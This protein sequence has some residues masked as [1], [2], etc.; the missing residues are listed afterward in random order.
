MWLQKE[1]VMCVKTAN[2]I[3]S[4][5]SIVEEEYVL[6]R[7]AKLANKQ[8]ET[9]RNGGR[10][11]SESEENGGQTRASPSRLLAFCSA[12]KWNIRPTADLPTEELP[13]TTSTRK[14]CDK[15]LRVYRP[16]QTQK[17]EKE[18]TPEKH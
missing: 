16:Y 10:S 9:R 4:L 3:G 17:H 11:G 13:D 15:D 5:R 1:E 8:T 12:A 7:I 14:L 2:H 6:G 18:E